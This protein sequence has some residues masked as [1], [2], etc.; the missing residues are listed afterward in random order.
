MTTNGNEPGI[1]TDADAQLNGV[2][3]IGASGSTVGYQKNVPGSAGYAS[4]GHVQVGVYITSRDFQGDRYP[5]PTSDAI[6]GNAMSASGIYGVSLYDAPDNPVRPF[7]SASHVLVQNRFRGRKVNFRDYAPAFD[8]GTWLPT[9]G[10]TTKHRSK[11]VRGVLGQE[12]YHGDAV[13]RSKPHVTAAL[14]LLRARPRVPAI[15]K[16]NGASWQTASSEQC[17]P[18][19]GR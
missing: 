2:V 19:R 17:W 16:P 10:S 9:K 11:V 5:A 3:I 7:T 12:A 18:A 1:P 15:W 14:V 6:S 8:A 13:T 4:S